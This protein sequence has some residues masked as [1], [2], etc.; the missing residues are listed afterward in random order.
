MDAE[1]KPYSIFITVDLF[2]HASSFTP[3]APEETFFMSISK[4]VLGLWLWRDVKMMIFFFCSV[5]IYVLFR[6]THSGRELQKFFQR[7]EKET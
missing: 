6:I 5:I 2:R 7:M 1:T 4:R 3:A